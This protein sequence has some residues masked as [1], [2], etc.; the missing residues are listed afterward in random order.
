AS[1][2]LDPPAAW[3]PVFLYAM[4]DS[5]RAPELSVAGAPGL[6]D[7]FADFNSPTR[8]GFPFYPAYIAGAAS[9]LGL[10]P[11]PALLRPQFIFSPN[12]A[13]VWS[14]LN[15]ANLEPGEIQARSPLQNRVVMYVS[16]PR[17]LA[18]GGVPMQARH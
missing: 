9:G 5:I 12:S 8:R 15:F 1:A 13:D 17:D 14:G 6:I 3:T 18:P 16:K 10:D 7:D 2:L 11:L 4:T